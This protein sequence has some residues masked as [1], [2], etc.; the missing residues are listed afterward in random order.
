MSLN[1]KFIRT[2]VSIVFRTSVS[3]VFTKKSK[4]NKQLTI[5]HLGVPMIYVPGQITSVRTSI[6]TMWT[7]KRLFSCM[8]SNMDN[9][10]FFR[11]FDVHANWTCKLSIIGHWCI[12]LQKKEISTSKFLYI[13]MFSFDMCCK[14]TILISFIT[15][16]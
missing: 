7:N 12:I 16:N 10:I 8:W 2:S 13:C 15:T 6:W 5:I 4:V 1:Y 11:W 3:I 14:R 9:H